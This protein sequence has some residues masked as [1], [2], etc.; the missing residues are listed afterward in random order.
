M[1]VAR[2]LV[3]ALL[4]G[5]I[6]LAAACGGDSGGGPVVPKTLVIAAGD[7]QSGL[8]G[9]TLATPLAVRL[10]GSDN[11]GYRDGVIT[12]T[13]T[14]GSATLATPTSTT[15]STGIANNTLTLGGTAG[16]VTV[17]AVLTSLAP[18]SFAAT[19]CDDPPFTF[20]SRVTGNLATTDCRF[21]GFYT[22]FYL[23]NLVDSAQ[24]GL[25]VTDSALTYDAYF[26]LYTNTGYYVGF[27]DDI[28]GTNTNAQ[29]DA[30]VAPGAYLLAPSS[31]SANVTGAYSL[32]AV[33][34]SQALA[35]CSLVWVTRGVSLA[36]SLTASDCT[37][38]GGFH[39][40]VVA[41]VAQTGTVIRVA[42]HSAA[43]NPKLQLLSSAGVLLAQN[44]DSAV[45]GTNS[46]IAYTVPATAA[47]VIMAGS[48]TAGETGAYT[49][50][51]SAATTL[52]GTAAE[53]PRGVAPFPFGAARLSKDWSRLWRTR[54]VSQLPHF[55]PSSAAK[56]P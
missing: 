1:R 28:S 42:Q 14:S 6:A 8:T 4:V 55:R 35:N 47:F 23:L 38:G 37:D 18:V 32:S 31:F 12:W 17:Q 22:D 46:Y 21:Q 33:A 56:T 50:D 40:D 30:I 49:M 41:I 54:Q 19:S 24:Q 5:G 52:T 16:Q 2:Q 43:I 45:T 15:D 34:R 13:V 39:G 36:D 3:A 48:S 44:D 53:A 9:V 29:L 27:D 20:G 7:S 25:T 11:R 51:I 26:E 10:L